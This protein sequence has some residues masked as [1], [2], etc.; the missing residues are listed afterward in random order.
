MV[1]ERHAAYSANLLM[2]NV[3]AADGPLSA[4]ALLGGADRPVDAWRSFTLLW[5]SQLDPAG[6]D[7]MTSSLAVSPSVDDLIISY[8]PEPLPRRTYYLPGHGTFADKIN[9]FVTTLTADPQSGAEGDRP[10]AVEVMAVHRDLT[11]TSV[12]VEIRQAD[13]VVARELRLAGRWSADIRNITSTAS[14]GLCKRIF[15]P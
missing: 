5:K 10:H 4:S 2:L 9:P 11:S 13:R 3:L 8:E 1:P 6:W 7:A 15:I 12:R 14:P